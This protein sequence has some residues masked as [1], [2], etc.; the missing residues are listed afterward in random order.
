MRSTCGGRAAGVRCGV[1]GNALRCAGV[2]AAMLG[3]SSVGADGPRAR[4][5]II[6][7]EGEI[8]DVL[9]RSV[10]RRIEE[11]KLQG[12]SSIVFRMNTPGGMVTSALDISAAIKKLPSENISTVAWVK[13]QAYS[14]GALISVA[15]QQIVM[16]PAGRIGDCAPIM[17]SPTGGLEELGGV[18]R[19]KAESPVLQDFRDSAG[20]HGYDA[21]LCRAMVQVGEEVWWL[22]NSTTQAREFVDAA[23]KKERMGDVPEGTR[24]WRLVETFIDPLSGRSVPVK[25]PIDSA[26][27]L[28]TLSQS[29]AVAF[30]LAKGIAADESALLKLLEL[31]AGAPLVLEVSGWESFARWLNDPAIRGV[32][33]VL[34]IIGAY[35][36]FQKPGVIIPGAI[37]AVCLAVF[38]GAPYAAGL[39]DIWTIVLLA[40]GAILLGVEVFVLP[41]F[42]VAGVA[43]VLLIV[44]SLLGTFVPREPGLPPFS[45]PQ[46]PGTYSS[47][48]TGVKVLTI[49]TFIGLAGIA[50]MLKYLPRTRFSRHFLL[51][52]T[53]NVE[54]LALD[55]YRGVGEVGE[56]GVV[57][58]ALRPGGAARFGHA[59][60]DVQSQGEYIEAGRRVQVV[61]HEGM[62]IVVRPVPDESV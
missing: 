11:A 29:E 26:S 28:L 12:V 62:T 8:T 4:V 9:A 19:A 38:L 47:L 44:V 56:V 54:A 6:P 14:A 36:E 22:E 1:R 39:A 3:L 49:G 51:P 41:G 13:D 55:P 30:G 50:L 25:Q 46:L 40:I 42:G 37:A 35:L 58:G 52:N 48:V 17:I 23:L 60:V 34:M 61:K 5:A 57:V 2:L 16:S 43:G 20:R 10:E 15:A 18:E 7:I 24:A 21:L 53:T 33:F 59:V 31:G 27:E 45:W 32:F